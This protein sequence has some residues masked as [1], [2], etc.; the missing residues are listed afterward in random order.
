MV[1]VT[2]T[3]GGG[4]ALTGWGRG[5]TTANRFLRALTAQTPPATTGP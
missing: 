5:Q 2:V 4:F 1:E 3:T